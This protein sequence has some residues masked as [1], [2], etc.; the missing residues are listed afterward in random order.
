MWQIASGHQKRSGYPGYIP[1][2]VLPFV[3][4]NRR[5]VFVVAYCWPDGE[6]GRS[7][8]VSFAGI[9]NTV[10]GGEG[11]NLVFR[12]MEEKTRG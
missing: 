12:V 4:C 2:N 1:L 7:G 6:E 5:G 9:L 10:P 11:Y 3:W 8:K